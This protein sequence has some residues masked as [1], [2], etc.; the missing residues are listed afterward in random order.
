M[1]SSSFLKSSK[2]LDFVKGTFPILKRVPVYVCRYTQR[3][4]Q[5]SGYFTDGEGRLLPLPE[6]PSHP[7]PPAYTGADLSQQQQYFFPVPQSALGVCK[8][9]C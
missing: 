2:F 4:L 9:P 6:T 5:A 3:S 7:G 8:D 1:Y